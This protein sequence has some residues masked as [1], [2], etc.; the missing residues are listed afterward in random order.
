MTTKGVPGLPVAI[1]A[2]GGILAWS[3]IYN[4]TLTS[5]LGSIL[6]GTKPAA[7]PQ[8]VDTD[9][10]TP[11]TSTPTGGAQGGSAS[12]NQA[13]AKLLC[14]PYGWSTG[15]EWDALVS[16]WTSE[17]GWSNTIWNSTAPC[18]NGAHAYGIPQSCGHGAMPLS[19]F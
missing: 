18:D 13:I 14:Q 8:T 1:I 6:K 16:L 5:A 19:L 3:G 12:A 7:G 10:S 9:I 2:A 17:S 11:A 15:A 4:Q